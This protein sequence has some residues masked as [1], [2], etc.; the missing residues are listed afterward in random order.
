MQATDADQRGAVGGG[1][2]HRASVG[3]R[4]AVEVFGKDATNNETPIVPEASRTA[5]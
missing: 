4:W 3:H 2:G 5:D 1:R